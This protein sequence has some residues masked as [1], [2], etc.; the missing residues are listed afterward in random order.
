MAY[1]FANEYLFTAKSSILYLSLACS[2]VISNIFYSFC[3]VC[4]MHLFCEHMCKTYQSW[5]I[6]KRICIYI[7]NNSH[8]NH[9][10]AKFFNLIECRTTDGLAFG[11]LISI[12]L[13]MAPRGSKELTVYL[14]KIYVYLCPLQNINL[15]CMCRKILSLLFI[16]LHN[17]YN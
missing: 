16:Y 11:I 10:E 15:L 13:C 5:Q 8:K 9:C 1:I 14:V 12:Y 17:F 6:H 7:C 4:A 3:K 2:N